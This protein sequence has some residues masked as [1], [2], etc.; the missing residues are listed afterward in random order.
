MAAADF[1]ARSSI[2]GRVAAQWT[3]S[4]RVLYRPTGVMASSGT[5]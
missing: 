4:S 1:E 3:C 2:S 5:W